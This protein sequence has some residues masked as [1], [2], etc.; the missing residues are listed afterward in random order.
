MIGEATLCS[1]ASG[2]FDFVYELEQG[3]AYAVGAMAVQDAVS[4][5]L[6]GTADYDE[7]TQDLSLV[8]HRRPRTLAK[9]SRY[10][11]LASSSHPG[12]L[13]L[14]LTK[15]YPRSDQIHHSQRKGIDIS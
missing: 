5:G 3:S 4:L 10:K 7:K 11:A 9:G 2:V 14:I 15:H 1:A 13:I 6:C 12:H 8:M